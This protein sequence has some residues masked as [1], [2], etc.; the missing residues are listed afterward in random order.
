MWTSAFL[1]SSDTHTICHLSCL[2]KGI[3]RSEICSL[4]NH[5]RNLCMHLACLSIEPV[6]INFLTSHYCV[7][8]LIREVSL[9]SHI[10]KHLNVH[11]LISQY[12]WEYIIAL[13]EIDL[14]I[15][16]REEKSNLTLHCLYI[17]RL[18]NQVIL[19]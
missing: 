11:F 6:P 5:I 15:M 8:Y 7:L 12:I 2:K 16:P 13:K 18:S 1:I 19:V 9:D 4:S 17:W 3:P 14:C 10:G